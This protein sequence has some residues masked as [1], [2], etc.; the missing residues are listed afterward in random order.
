[1]P[2]S[3]RCPS[4]HRWRISFNNFQAADALVTEPLVEVGCPVL[5]F[6]GQWNE[7]VV[8]NEPVSA[9]EEPSRCRRA[10]VQKT[11]IAW[12][13]NHKASCS[14][15]AMS[16]TVNFAFSTMGPMCI[17]KVT[18]FEAAVIGNSERSK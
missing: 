10:R 2:E 8:F 17:V 5:L 12:A 9:A 1:M 13:G 15:Y 18:S 4:R 3:L 16:F 14:L 7:V 6:G 11:G